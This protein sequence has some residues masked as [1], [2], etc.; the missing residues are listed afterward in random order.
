MAYVPLVSLERAGTAAEEAIELGAS[1]LLVSYQCPPDHA[2]SH[3]ALDSV[4]ALVTPPDIDGPGGTDPVPV[5]VPLT[6]NGTRHEAVYSLPGAL[7]GTYTVTFYASDTDGAVSL[8]DG[9]V[10]ASSWGS[11][12]VQILWSTGGLQSL[13]PALEQPADIG[14]DVDRNRLLVPLLGP[15]RL[16][17]WELSR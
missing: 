17:I 16:E 3:K 13:I 5:E 1:A 2:P 9:R 10:F 14:F 11:S 6:F 4:W 15:G 7:G 8:P 12:D